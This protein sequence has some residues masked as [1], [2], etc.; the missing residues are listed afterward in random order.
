MKIKPIYPI[1]II[2]SFLLALTS[3]LAKASFDNWSDPE[4]LSEWLTN[5]S[6]PWLLGSKDGTHVVFWIDYDFATNQDALQARVRYPVGE[7]SAIESVFG[8][9]EEYP[10]D[11]EF[12]AAPDGTF[13]AL[14]AMADKNQPGDN[15][16]LVAASWK[17]NGPW[18]TEPISDYE[19][20]VRNID[21]SIGPEGHIAATWVACATTSSDDQGPCD[22]RVRR[23]N[24]GA[25]TWELNNDSLDTAI[26]GIVDARSRVSPEG[27][28]VTTWGEYSQKANDEW[29]VMSASY[30]PG[31]KT[32]DFPP[33]EIS[34][35]GFM[36]GMNP[37]MTKPV[38]GT[39]GTVIVGWYMLNPSQPNKSKL[40]TATRQVSPGKWDL[41]ISL[42][43]YHFPSYG[44]SLR[45]ALGQ[46][47][48][49]VAAWVEK[50][51]TTLSEYALYA[52]QRDPGDSWLSN[53][54]KITNWIDRIVLAAPQVWP[55]GS[56]LLLWKAVDYRRPVDESQSV[57][58]SARS[59]KGDW[60]DLGDGQLGNWYQE[61][62]SVSAAA[63]DN[64]GITAVWG[65]EDTSRPPGEYAGALAASWI[66]GNGDIPVSTITSGYHSIYLN[67]QSVLVSPDGA[68][69]S[70]AWG[71]RKYINSPNLTAVD[72]VFYAVGIGGTH[73][74]Y[75]PLVVKSAP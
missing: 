11:P 12:A 64:G 74:D 61:I 50:R 46:D 58:W 6:N 56:A 41:P 33:E 69:S 23:R 63:A 13:W 3:Y 49:A 5:L 2:M 35:G 34:D 73:R 52:N 45:L 24:P 30:D 19:T 17:E 47:G 22:V 43:D 21:L 26:Y 25:A 51:G 9:V 66:P 48:T 71:A 75:L 32:W 4:N 57:F 15:M 27:L 65:I 31:L 10:V 28:I 42:S 67:E 59:P 37:F 53:P 60:G 54:V 68:T 29:L 7:W 18:Q 20:T 14:W 1:L 36:P 38:M 16:Q 62:F 40:Y 8:T 44:N 70:A 72:A 55:D 39:D